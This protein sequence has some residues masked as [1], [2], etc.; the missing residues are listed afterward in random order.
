LVVFFAF[1]LF[2]KSMGSKIGFFIQNA[3][4]F[5]MQTQAKLKNSMKTHV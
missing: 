1:L 5:A 3:V 4:F 2:A